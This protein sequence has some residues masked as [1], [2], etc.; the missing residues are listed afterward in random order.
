M[1]AVRGGGVLCEHATQLSRFNKGGEGY[2]PPGLFSALVFD[3]LLS[4]FLLLTLPHRHFHPATQFSLHT[5]M[6]SLQLVSEHVCA[7]SHHHAD[8][9]PSL[10]TLPCASLNTTVQQPR[11]KDTVYADRANTADPL[12]ADYSVP[13]DG[14]E[15][16]GGQALGGDVS[17]ENRFRSPS[18]SQLRACLERGD[19]VVVLNPLPLNN[20]GG[21]RDTYLNVYTVMRTQL[22]SY[23]DGF[24]MHPDGY[25]G[26]SRYQVVYDALRNG[27]QLLQPVPWVSSSN[28]SPV[29]RIPEVFLDMTLTRRLVRG[30][31]YAR[32]YKLLRPSDRAGKRSSYTY[33][34]PCSNRGQCD[35]AEGICRCFPGYVLDDCSGQENDVL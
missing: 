11:L 19:Q 7:Y 23:Y 4:R 17:C 3:P 22:Q 8:Y 20:L 2:A 13:L 5:T 14:P 27:S 29:V 34:S 15:Q 12:Y 16:S 9:L 10:Y 18:A 26:F 6:A 32:L 24:N 1:D 35:E 33:V 28:S 21:Y 25:R 30:Q 31:D